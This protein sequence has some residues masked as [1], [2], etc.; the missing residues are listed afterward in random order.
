MYGWVWSNK[1]NKCEI[2]KKTTD[3]G[4]YKKYHYPEYDLSNYSNAKY[5][6]NMPDTYGREM[7]NMKYAYNEPA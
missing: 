5:D 3:Y 7:S 4:D 1:T 2:D 6:N